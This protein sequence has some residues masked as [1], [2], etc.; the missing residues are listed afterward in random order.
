MPALEFTL[1]FSSD[2]VLRYYRGQ[3]RQV[4]AYLDD[5][6]SVQ[7]PASALQKVVTENGVHGRFRLLFDEHHKFV[8]LQRLPAS[9]SA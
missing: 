7:F 2:E 9:F 6:R 8:G 3:S 4:I 5:G 1:H